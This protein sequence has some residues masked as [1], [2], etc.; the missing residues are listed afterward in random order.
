MTPSL[1]RSSRVSFDTHRRRSTSQQKLSNTKRTDDDDESNESQQPPTS[2]FPT[3]PSSPPNDKE[4]NNSDPSTNPDVSKGFSMTRVR[5]LSALSQ[6][7]K[8]GSSNEQSKSGNVNKGFSSVRKNDRE[9][10]AGRTTS[11]TSSATNKKDNNIL[12]K[13]GSFQRKNRDNK[14]EFSSLLP[15]PPTKRTEKSNTRNRDASSQRLSSWED[16]LGG[17]QPIAD[18]MAK[19]NDTIV[20]RGRNGDQPPRNVDDDKPDSTTDKLPS[21]S[22]LFPPDLSSSSTSLERFPSTDNASNV[23]FSRRSSAM[24]GILPVSDLFYRSSQS[25]NEDDNSKYDNY[26]TEPRRGDDEELPSSAE[27]SDQLTTT[28]NKIKFRRNRANRPSSNETPPSAASIS[29]KNPSGSSRRLRLVRRGIEMLVGGVP[30]NADPPQRCVELFYRYKPEDPTDWYQVIS[31][32]TR[33]FGP[34]LHKDS[35]GKLSRKERG[36]FCEFFVNSTLK[37]NVCP[38][39]LRSIAKKHDS[40]HDD[41]EDNDTIMDEMVDSTNATNINSVEDRGPDD[42]IADDSSQVLGTMK[43]MDALSE[44]DSE[45]MGELV[46]SIGV[47]KEELESCDRPAEQPVLERVLARGILGSTDCTGFDVVFTKLQ[48]SDLQDGTTMITADFNISLADSESMAFVDLRKKCQRINTSLARAMDD[49]DMQLSMAS[50]AKEETAWPDDLRSRIVEEFLFDDDEDGPVTGDDESDLDDNPSFDC[51]DASAKPQKEEPS[52]KVIGFGDD[53]ENSMGSGSSFSSSDLSL[54]GMGDGVIWNYAA[55]NEPNSPYQGRLGL[56]LV[57]AVVEKAKQRHPRVIAIGDV[58]GCIDELQDL[59]RECDYRPG[60]LVVFLGDLVSKGP[61]SVAVVQM[62]REIGAI[63]VRG[64]HDF[65]TVRWH[66]AIK[67]GVDPPIAV[68]EHFHI[69]NS[70]TNADMKWMYSLPWYI[71]SPDLGALFV[72]AG[73]V[74]GIR[75]AKQNPRLMMNMRSILPDG[76]VTSKFFNNWPWARLWDGPQTV[77]FGHDA[78]RGLQQYEHAIG[79]DT[80]CVYGGR[81]TACILPEKRLVSVSA[82][83]SYF[84]YRR[85]HYD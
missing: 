18:N 32:D 68:S 4:N 51:N 33:D 58:H 2:I 16:F 17:E 29:N 59:L 60:D 63:G 36:L 43:E 28:Q 45:L 52:Y 72:H 27:Q 15:P 47:S 14:I 22:D 20:S 71:S 5:A 84:K 69:A 23:T 54:G 73:F 66:Q 3:D 41:T 64:N 25:I 26:A 13:G 37:W 12:Q 34:M 83:K 49:G 78:D 77:L 80:G 30:I 55:K 1:H 31:T 46:F 8:R 81:L 10:S 85:K 75:L 42:I 6:Q 65:E 7:P 61:D 82:R 44:S 70:L 35:V 50:A 74:S 39:D 24:E 56:R 67:A 76:T 48:L 38:K 62:A 11:R 53:P 40:T 19:Q 57:D 21:I 9:G 79:L